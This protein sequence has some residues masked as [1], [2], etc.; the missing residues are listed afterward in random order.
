MSEMTVEPLKWKRGK[1]KQYRR[2]D[3]EPGHMVSVTCLFPRKLIEELEDLIYEDVFPS[4]TEAIR[5]AVLLLLLMLRRLE[6]KEAEFLLARI[7]T[8]R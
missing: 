1:G 2:R 6:D 4:R 7:K 5:T 3:P 8:K